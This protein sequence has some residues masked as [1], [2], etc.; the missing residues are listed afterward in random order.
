MKDYTLS[1]YSDGERTKICFE[2]VLSYRLEGSYDLKHFQIRENAKEKDFLN[3]LVSISQYQMDIY[4]PN[5]DEIVKEAE[6][7]KIIQRAKG[8]LSTNASEKFYLKV[9]ELMAIEEEKV[10][11]PT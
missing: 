9:R 11:R 5:I 10:V 6:L 2:K 1:Y 4:H 8:D 3:L 7:F